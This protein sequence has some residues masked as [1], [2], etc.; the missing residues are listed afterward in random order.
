MQIPQ[1]PLMIKPSNKSGPPVPDLQPCGQISRY[2]NNWSNITH[3]K[4][5]LKIVKEG[6]KI[7][8]ISH[9]VQ[10]SPIISN[11][12]SLSSKTSLMEQINKNLS[13]GAISVVPKS[14]NHFVS[15][16]FTVKKSNGDD[17]MIIDLS[18]LNE[19]VNKVTF[20]ME[21]LD[22]IKSL[23]QPDDFM[24]SVDLSN[25]F[26]S[27]PLHEDSKCFTTFEFNNTR[28]VYNVL[29]FGLS[30]SPRIFSK[31]LRPVIT[32]FRSQ[33]FKISAYLDD[34]FFCNSSEKEAAHQVSVVIDTLQNLGFTPNFS[35]SV[36]VPTQTL[37]HLGFIWDSSSMTLNLPLSK[38]E[39]TRNFASS[40]L[41]KSVV[42]LR[43]ISSFLGLLTSLS[44]A[45]CFAPLHYR[46]I[47]LQFVSELQIA[48]SWDH[49]YSLDPKA[50]K[51]VIW[52]SKDF[53][54]DPV[55]LS[56][57]LIDL[58]MHTDASLTGWGCILSNDLV[59]SGSWTA[60]ESKLHIN[61]L[62][63]KAIHFGLL[64]F[65]SLI[66]NKNVQI[67]SDNSTAVSYI[68]KMGGTHSHSLCTL[69]LDIWSLTCNLGT[70]INAVHLPGIE[71]DHADFFSR[72]DNNSHDYGISQET[73]KDILDALDMS[74]QVDLF[75]SR[76]NH[77][78][79]CYVS[80]SF[81]PFA[82][83]VDAFAISWPS[84]VYM[85]PPISLINKTLNKF[86]EE[87]SHFGILITPA[88][89]GMPEIPLIVQLLFADPI[90]IPDRYLEGNR[91][92]R[93]PF[94]LAVWSISTD[95]TKTQAYLSLRHKRCLRASRNPPSSLT[96]STG[97]NSIFGMEK[98]GIICQSLYP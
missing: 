86:K 45:L 60:T 70:K 83:K 28:Y 57:Q 36:L 84:S 16:V 24:M 66:K 85:F 73:F 67:F 89:P 55:G 76:L 11:P 41:K 79:P 74:P 87:N 29:P 10:R 13:I 20:K 78:L 6:Y 9:P 80:R 50:T 61:F 75:A 22:V 98:M 52:W 46:F 27:I 88:W 26:F 7:Q 63:L 69:A 56:S 59:A 43:E 95:K 51:E 35:K 17:R 2:I 30:C 53:P 4:F 25:A 14:N 97:E 72:T 37:P 5:I 8:F 3:N 77:K 93:F 34:I 49:K 33:G 15:R 96:S 40:L 48:F 39:K 62:E 65:S 44:N 54:C 91:P 19:F 32:W 71:N 81:D 47:Q 82:W 90:I 64:C 58:T 21:G 38:K 23:L 94:Q 92:T 68:N 31:M 42:S 18:D 1:N 12:K